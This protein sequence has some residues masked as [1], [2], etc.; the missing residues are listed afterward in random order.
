MV[1]KICIASLR[2]ACACLCAAT[3]LAAYLRLTSEGSV[4]WNIAGSLAFLGLSAA[5][6][7]AGSATFTE[8]IKQWCEH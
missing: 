3:L 1:K 4:G 5:W 7:A 2:V 6:L 8:D